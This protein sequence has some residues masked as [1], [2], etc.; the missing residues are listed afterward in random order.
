MT[1]D[2]AHP[3]D[4]YQA[5]C[6]VCGALRTPPWWEVGP[7]VRPCEVGYMASSPDGCS[8]RFAIAGA[9]EADAARNWWSA[10]EG[11]AFDGTLLD[12]ENDRGLGAVT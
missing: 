11:L 2:C 12:D 10:L 7:S 9:S 3:D 6:P 4:G 8:V 5:A 1:F